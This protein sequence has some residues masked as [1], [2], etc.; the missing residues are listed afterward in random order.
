MTIDYFT[1]EQFESYLRDRF[2]EKWDFAGLARGELTYIIRYHAVAILIRSSIKEDDNSAGVGEDSIRVFLVTDDTERAL[3]AKLD[4]LYVTRV[5]GWENRLASKIDKL[6]RLRD[7]AGDC[8]TCGEPL[9]IFTVQKEGGNQGR[10][11]ASCKDREHKTFLWLDQPTTPYWNRPIIQ[12]DCNVPQEVADK[13]AA[14]FAPPM[15]VVNVFPGLTENIEAAKSITASSQEEEEV[16]EESTTNTKDW[17]AELPPEETPADLEMILHEEQTF[18]VPAMAAIVRVPNVE[19]DTAIH[20]DVNKP[21]R[22]IAGAGSGKTFVISLRYAFMVDS[23]INP[24]WIVAVTFSK[25]MANELLNR[26][27]NVTP[28]PATAQALICT[29]HALTFRMLRAFYP[30]YKKYMVATNFQCKKSLEKIIVELEPYSDD[31]PSW[32]ETFSWICASKSAGVEPDDVSGWLLRNMSDFSPDQA[33][34][35]HNARLKFDAGMRADNL[36]T[37]ADMLYDCEH[38]LLQDSLFLEYWQS[39]FQYL[40][41]DEAQ[42][43]GHQAMRILRRLFTHTKKVTIVGDPDQLLYRFA[44]ATPEDNMYEGFEKEYPG[45]ATVMLPTNYRSTKN[46]VSYGLNVIANNYED[47]GPYPVKYLKGL[48]TPDTAHDGADV[49]LTSYRDPITES[50]EIVS[51]IKILLENEW[52]PEHFFVAARTRAQVGYLEASFALSGIPYVNIVGASFLDLMHVRQVL[53]YMRIIDDPSNQEA[54]KDIYNVASNN[55]IFP[56][57]KS[58]EYGQYVPHR[59]LTAEFLAT[60]RNLNGSNA[61]YS[62][63]RNKRW[64]WEPG[65][66]DISDLTSE[67]QGYDEQGPL[68]L[69]DG[70][71]DLCYRKYTNF[72][73]GGDESLGDNSSRMDDLL[74]LRDLATPYKDTHGF[75]QFVDSLILAM[76]AAQTKDWSGRVVLSTIHRLKGL[77][78]RCVIG[79]GVSEGLGRDPKS[80]DPYGLL[81]HTFSLTE[82][83]R[84]GKLPGSGRGRVEDERCLFYVLITRA[85]E[86]L[87]LSSLET[88]RD[89]PMMASRFISEMVNK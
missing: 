41:V 81:P 10:P 35:V 72:Q 78:R 33:S 40:I 43:T 82:P 3:L 16:V 86:L 46:I 30:Y 38:A 1:R 4:S 5:R 68:A 51:T 2:P 85:K 17:L 58:A 11:F 89:K 29:I 70:I 60:V 69:F 32:E 24:N 20:A 55:M 62:D 19:Q 64:G 76:K 47:L 8:S 18:I 45:A 75:L 66:K 6:M 34:F 48:N 67:L 79:V 77:E 26:I 54:F 84:N 73:T 53:S 36:I 31:R 50:R 56:W 42:D 59:F 13:I 71:I 25:E 63:Y 14:T 9:H 39:R 57:K 83:P 65:M 61:K 74:T 37:F 52:S 23:G 80:G 15:E 27:I 88:Y 12:V 44:G 7:K 87:I 28:I 21:L 22:L 49:L